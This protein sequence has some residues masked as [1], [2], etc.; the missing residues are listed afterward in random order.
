MSA[1][2]RKHVP[3]RTCIACH[4][5][6]PKREL[7]RVVRR[8]EGGIEVDS[9]KGKLPGRGAY[10]CPT[11]R[12]CEEALDV[13]KLGRAL[14]CQVSAE[15]IASL[16]QALLPLLVEQAADQDTNPDLGGQPVE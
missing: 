11:R 2:R 12:C 5:K 13:K 6:R 10:V 3:L 9:E 16:R 1:K 15:D 8:P 7:W 4:Q 14:K